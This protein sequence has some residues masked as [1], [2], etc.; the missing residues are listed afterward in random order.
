M[1][2]NLPAVWETQTQSLD[3]ENALE[4]GKVTHSS[5]PAWEI[6]WTEKPDELQSMGTQTVYMTEWLTLSL[7]LAGED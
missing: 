4:N 1:V 7:G 3:W 2:K 6:L 5:I